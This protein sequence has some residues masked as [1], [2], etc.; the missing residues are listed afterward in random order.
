MIHNF[1]LKGLNFTKNNLMS[2]SILNT[3]D[4]CLR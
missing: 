4:F 1:K 3:G 2:C